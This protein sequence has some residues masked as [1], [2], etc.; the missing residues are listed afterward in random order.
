MEQPDQVS[1][2]WHLLSIERAAKEFGLGRDFLR[3]AVRSGD[4][5]SIAI[6]R[7]RRVPRGALE[8]WIRREAN[9]GQEAAHDDSTPSAS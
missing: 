4:V 2:R 6:G 7:Q 9:L 8:D 5:P 3:S 1:G